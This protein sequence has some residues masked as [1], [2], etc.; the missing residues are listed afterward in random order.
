[1]SPR[2][3]LRAMHTPGHARGHL[4][5][6]EERTRH[7][8]LRR[9]HRRAWVRCLIDPPEGNMRDYLD[10][11]ERMRALPNLTVIFGG[12]G[13]AIANPY[14]EDRRIHFAS[15]RTRTKDSEAVRDGRDDTER[16]RCARLHRRLSESSRD[17]RTRGAGA[18]RKARSRWSRI[19]DQ[20]GCWT[21]AMKLHWTSSPLAKF[22]LRVFPSQ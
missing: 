5:F 13:P 12:H 14:A 2:F 4:C 7:V 20:D 11:L 19:S 6:H 16:D 9:Q 8:D 10:S 17:G 1:M 22:S 21:D 15:A 18:S 3:S